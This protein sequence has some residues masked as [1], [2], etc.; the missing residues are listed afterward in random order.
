M[1]NAAWIVGLGL[2]VLALVM[3]SRTAEASP[4]A[5][6]FIPDIHDVATA[7]N[8]VELDTYYEL[9]NELHVRG[10][11]DDSTYEMFYNTY[12]ARYE[13]LLEQ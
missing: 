7:E 2:G 10:E 4:P 8:M 13:E 12:L 9:I 11:M 3:L 1:S 5:E 6:V